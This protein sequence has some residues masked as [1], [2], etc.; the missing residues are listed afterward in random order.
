MTATRIE[1]QDYQALSKDKKA[2][3]ESEAFRDRFHTF[4]DC[5]SSQMVERFLQAPYE[6]QIA[7]SVSEHEIKS[8]ISPEL[9]NSYLEVGTMRRRVIVNQHATL[10]L[11]YVM[12]GEYILMGHGG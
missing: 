10:A 11:I 8:R 2:F 1:Q 5:N 6:I 7:T 12:V 9:T 4:G 3:N